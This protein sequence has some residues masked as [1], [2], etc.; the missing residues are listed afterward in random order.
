MGA[1][2]G[3]LVVRGAEEKRKP[4]CC[5]FAMGST[6]RVEP[7]VWGFPPHCI[8]LQRREELYVGS[9]GS[10]RLA[11]GLVAIHYMRK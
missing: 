6:E 10:P 1:R 2:I 9:A 11:I 3:T 8:H 7:I 5:L 4:R